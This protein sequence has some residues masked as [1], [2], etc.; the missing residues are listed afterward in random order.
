LL[1][2]LNALSQITLKAT[3]PGMPDFYQG[4]EFW[5][6]SLVDPDNRRPV[7]FA[8]RASMLP[9]IETP[10]WASLVRQW[11]DGRL[12]LAWTRELL[13]LRTE[14]AEVFT[15]G[16]YQPLEVSGTHRDH[17]IA[18]ARR[19]GRDAAIIA[20]AKSFATFTQGGRTWPSGEAFDGTLSIRGYAAE[21]GEN[22]L[23]LSRLFFNLPVAV[24]KAKAVAASKSARQRAHAAKS[25]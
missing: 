12:K 2:A 16:G 15:E 13:K 18:F 8:A 1:G 24:L 23:Q 7:D 21:A 19:R 10:D 5:D 22:G 9:S 4:T 3:M 20:V 6:L 14:L 17:V 25:P 11:P